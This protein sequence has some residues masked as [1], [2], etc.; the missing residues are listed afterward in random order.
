[1]L[2]ILTHIT[3]IGSMFELTIDQ[4]HKGQRSRS[5]MQLEE[6]LCFEY[7]SWTND[8]ILRIFTNMIEINERK[9]LT[10]G[11]GH[12]V[13]GQGQKYSYAKQLVCPL[14]TNEK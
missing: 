10:L 11:Q 2:M 3:S 14:N 5:N 9:K 6:K 8:W 13:K 4:G 7:K 1:M 12:K